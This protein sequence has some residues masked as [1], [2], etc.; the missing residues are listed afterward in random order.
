MPFHARR[1]VEVGH[2]HRAQ[3]QQHRGVAEPVEHDHPAGGRHAAAEEADQQTGEGRTGD[4]RGVE[5]R[6]VEA[7]GVAEVLGTDHLAHEAL[8]GRGVE[9]R[10]DPEDEGEHVDVP[11]LD[12]AGDREGTQQERGEGHHGLGDHQQ[13]LLGEAVGDQAGVRREEQRGQELEPGRDAER[14]AVVGGEQHDQPVLG[15]ALHPG[16]GV[17]HD[18]ARGVQA[19]VVVVQGAERGTQLMVANL[20]RSGATSRRRARSSGVRSRSRCASQ[21]SRRRR[22]ARR[23]SRPLSVRSTS[24]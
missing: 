10:A 19:V 5:R 12:G 2:D 18:T 11:D 22:S 24:T 9:G 17:R 23:I 1:D 16:A 20:W 7:D 15:H 13:A 8:A 6:G 4:A 21:A 3:R 14:R